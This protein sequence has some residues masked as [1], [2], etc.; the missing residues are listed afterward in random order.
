MIARSSPGIASQA[1]FGIPPRGSAAK[2]NASS[3]SG[4]Q[5]ERR[6]IRNG[7]LSP[8]PGPA[9]RDKNAHKPSSQNSLREAIASTGLACFLREKLQEQHNMTSSALLYN[10]HTTMGGSSIGVDPTNRTGIMD[11]SK[12]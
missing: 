5:Q 3:N 4:H 6:T 1:A 9:R 2:R 10:D 7:S 11:N 12:N 8:G